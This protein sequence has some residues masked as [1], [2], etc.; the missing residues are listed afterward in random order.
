M[1]EDEKKSG[2]NEFSMYKKFADKVYTAKK[3]LADFIRSAKSQGKSI[4]A[5]GAPAKGNT[6][7]SFCNIGADCID[8]IVEDNP[9]KIGLFTPGTHIPVVSS[10]MLDE[11][12]PDYILILAWNFAHEILAKTKKYSDMGVKFIIPLPVPVEV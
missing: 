7:L 4:A 5:Y 8:Y 12:K 11:K 2:I 6:L 9:L 1:L 3:K 10:K